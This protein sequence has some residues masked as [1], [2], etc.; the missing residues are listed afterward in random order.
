MKTKKLQIKHL[1]FVI[2]SLNILILPKMDVGAVDKV[3]WQKSQ[4]YLVKYKNQQEIKLLDN[5]SETAAFCS[6]SN[7]NSSTFLIDKL[8]LS[9]DEYM[10]IIIL[11]NN[12]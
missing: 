4:E 6:S 2:L 3:E 9:K 5:I 12:S 8:S 10:E 1:I 11:C 7:I